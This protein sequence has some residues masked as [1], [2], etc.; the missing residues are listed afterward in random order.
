MDTSAFS[1]TIALPMTLR[2]LA[3]LILLIIVVLSLMVAAS[4]IER[5]FLFYPSHDSGTNG[6]APWMRNGEVIGYARLVPAPRN[7]WLMLHGNGGQAADRLY[8][9]PSFSS[10]DSVF[11]MEYPGYGGRPGLPSKGAFNRAAKEAYLLLRETYPKIPVCVA[12]ESLGSGPS[13]FLAGLGQPPDKV[14][15]IVPFDKL[16]LVAGERFPAF[17]VAL[18]LRDNWDNVAALSHYKGPVDIF[19]AADDAI[20]PVSHARALAAGLPGSRLTIVDGGH[21][22]WASPGRVRIRNP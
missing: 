3:P 18:L 21:N 1:A 14:V 4:A 13:S 20:I 2:S 6:L 15:L 12:G 8:A 7:I 11:I 17:L 10:G 16:S 22:E 5:K 9:L 19:G